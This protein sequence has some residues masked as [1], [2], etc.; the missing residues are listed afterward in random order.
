MLD[1][2]VA[3]LDK[4]MTEAEVDE[5]DAQA[6]YESFISDAA[7][8]RAQ[9]SKAVTDKEAAKADAETALHTA[10]DSSAAK[11]ADLMATEEYISE[12]HGECD[13][14]L[15]NFELR[16]EARAGE[17]DS[18]KAAKAVLAGADFS[19]VQEHKSPKTASLRG[20]L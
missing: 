17:V 1:M 16:K 14:L 3:D 13:W 2:L 10:K 20:T 12:L 8:K 15:K 4:E 5:K 9:D 18:L 6:A 19:L 11:K 7:A